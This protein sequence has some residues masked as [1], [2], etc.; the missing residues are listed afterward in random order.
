MPYS[1]VSTGGLIGERDKHQIGD[2]GRHCELK[3]VA[4][5]GAAR[6]GI[7]NAQPIS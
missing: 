5:L 2:T 7:T 1:M 3:S 4:H 6:Y